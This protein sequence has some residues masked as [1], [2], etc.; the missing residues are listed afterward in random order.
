MIER[1][2]WRNLWRNRRRT[3]IT[4]GSITFAVLF[5]IL[6][7]SFQKGIFDHLIENVVG[8]YHGNLQV[9]GAGYWA[10]QIMDNSFEA[11]D[12]MM[13]QWAQQKHVQGIVPRMESFMLASNDS[14]TKGCMVVGTDPEREDQL[15]HLK[16]RLKKGRY[17]NNDE[18]AILLAEGLAER[19]HLAV[20]DTMVLIGQGYQA[21]LAAGKYPVAG[22]VHFGSPTINNSMAYLPLAQA[23]YLQGADGRLTSIAFDIDDPAHLTA[24]QHDVKAIAGPGYEVMTWSE[25][26]PEIGSMIR[27]KAASFYI[28]TG[29]LYLIIGFGIFGTIL[30]MTAER[31]YEFGMLVA[32]GMKK[33]LMGRMLFGETLLITLLGAISGV[34]ISLPIVW[35]MKARPIRATGNMAEVYEQ[36]GFEAVLPTALDWHIFL[37]QSLTVLIIAF[38]IGLY[39]LWHTARLDPVRAMRGQ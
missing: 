34:L 37:Q 23:Q 22:I 32:I 12:A 10:E 24:L 4:T 31:R 38:V 30:M 33:S 3:L 21:S 6:M 27:G 17:I 8:F 1:L 2:T 13:N 25:M 28:F 36:F 5:A 11:D 19:L 15:T 7:Q 29:I 39:P 35:Y 18:S 20:G 26:M 14:I 16:S 9:H